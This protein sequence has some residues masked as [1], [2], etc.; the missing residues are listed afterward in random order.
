MFGV[1]ST[2]STPNPRARIVKSCLKVFS[3]DEGRVWYPVYDRFGPLTLDELVY[4]LQA[5]LLE[6]EPAYF[7]LSIHPCGPSSFAS[8]SRLE[9][10]IDG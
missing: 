3:S 5:G 9:E 2:S 10:S 1:N 4:R 6:F 8:T 7:A